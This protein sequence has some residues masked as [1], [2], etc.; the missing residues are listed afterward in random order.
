MKKVMMAAIGLM[1]AVSVN[2]QKYLNDSDTPFE[3]GKVYISGTI[4]TASLAYSKESKFN[5][6]LAGRAGYFLIDNLMGL[7]QVGFVS[8]QGGDEQI[9]EIG[10]G[11]RYYFDQVGLYVGLMANFHHDKYMVPAI[12]ESNL[13]TLSLENLMSLGDMKAETSNEFRP[14]LYVG[15]AFFLG[16]HITLEPEVYFSPSFKNSDQTNFGLN[17]G[18]G[19]YF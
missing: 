15:Y 6:G 3:Q 5:I 17:I 11:A 7:G 2:A 9:F 12:D 13:E 1:M 10:A 14:E 16:R 8:T 4:S 18:F 19:I